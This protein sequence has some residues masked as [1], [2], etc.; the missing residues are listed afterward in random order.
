MMNWLPRKGSTTS[1]FTPRVR[2]NLPDGWF[3]KESTTLLAPNGQANVIVS[4][5]PLDPQISGFRYAEIQGE[6]LRNEF[7]GFIEFSFG[8]E[9][10]FGGRDG[11][12]RN[13]QWQ[14]PDGV[15]VRQVQVYCVV[16]GRGF[17]ATATTPT[18]AYDDYVQVLLGCLRSLTLG[19]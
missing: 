13:F 12:V 5:E 17:C 4:G 8:P 11:Y 19:D 18:I 15:P 1:E 7:P 9:L 3:A 14:P 2:S 16:D 6:L 10:V